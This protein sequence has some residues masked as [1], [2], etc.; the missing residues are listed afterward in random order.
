MDRESS[1]ELVRALTRRVMEALCPEKLPDFVE[2]FT[3]FALEAGAP[4]VSDVSASRKRSDQDLDTTLVAGMF[5]QVL[6]EAEKLPAS[7]TERVSFLRKGAKNYLVTRLAGRISLNQFFRL[8]NLIEEE[9]LHYFQRR[10]GEWVG[11]KAMAPPKAEPPRPEKPVRAETLRQALAQ[12]PITPKGRRRLTLEGLFDFLRETQGRWFRLLDFE[13]RFQV[14]KK[15]A[16]TYLNL[17]LKQNI[18]E[19]NGEKANKVR[20]ALA[21]RFRG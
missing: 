11:L 3:A 4:R 9:A 5:F 18:L 20:Y 15:T 8:L 13:A 19:H 7:N 14:N 2:D 21:P 16:W 6:M 12:L 10:R 17:L 1:L